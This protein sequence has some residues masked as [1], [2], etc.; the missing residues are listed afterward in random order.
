MPQEKRGS[1]SSMETLVHGTVWTSTDT[2]GWSADRQRDKTNGGSDKSKSILPILSGRWDQF[3]AVS[4]ERMSMGGAGL[5][6]RS[7]AGEL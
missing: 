7:R 2:A 5:T 4:V 1:K 6:E 3:A